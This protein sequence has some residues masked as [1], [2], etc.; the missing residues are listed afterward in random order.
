MGVRWGIWYLNHIK[1]ISEV[2]VVWPRPFN[3]PGLRGVAARAGSVHLISSMD[4]KPNR[5]GGARPRPK[6][7]H[8]VEWN[9]VSSCVGCVAE[10]PWSVCVC[11]G[12]EEAVC[13]NWDWLWASGGHPVA[14]WHL[15]R[16]VVLETQGDAV[17]GVAS[18]LPSL[19][20][21][22]PALAATPLR[23]GQLKGRGHTTC[24]S[25]MT[26]MWFRCCIPHLTPTHLVI[27]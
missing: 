25:L 10:R 6:Q 18:S 9:E 22:L 19:K 27:P 13:F 23:P 16:M 12:L 2:H 17:L 20:W 3:C 24:T 8:P 14:S 1:V 4:R 11:F 15:I 7:H 21:T 26:S 5:K